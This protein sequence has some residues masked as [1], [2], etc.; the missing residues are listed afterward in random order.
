MAQARSPSQRPAMSGHASRVLTPPA[1]AG[2]PWRERMVSA[3]PA[4][5]PL[6][7][8]GCACGGRCPRC[9]NPTGESG[10]GPEP[11]TT[12]PR[13]VTADGEGAVEGGEVGA[14]VGEEAVVAPAAPAAP[15]RRARLRS[16]PRY[17]PRGNLTPTL[18]GGLKNAPFVF[19]AVFDS[20]PSEGVFPSCGEIHQDIKWNLAARTNG[21]ALWGLNTPHGGFPAA[22]PANTWIEDRDGTDTFRYGHRRGPFAT[23]VAGG[24][25]YT[26][27]AGVVNM[28]N[29]ATYHGSD[30][31]SNV[32]AAFTGRWTFMVL[33]F[34][35]CNGGTQVG[36][37]DFV[38][39][40][41]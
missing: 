21:N 25:T 10:S 37:A 15:A 23:P 30:N 7:K 31:P 1:R 36:S 19:D 35:M 17:T 6:P 11:L 9:A 26:N 32:P 14:K 28:A 4:A 33:A 13:V 38:I 3:G 22:H 27:D 16:G 12:A 24:N 29:G 8:S 18:A 5:S 20:A 40:D 34:D 39:I 41:W 2:D